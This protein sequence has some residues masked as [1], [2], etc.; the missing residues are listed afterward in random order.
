MT[1]EGERSSKSLDSEVR[2]M[3]AGVRSID[4]RKQLPLPIQ[5]D[6]KKEEWSAQIQKSANFLL[7]HLCQPTTDL[8][9]LPK[10]L[11]PRD[12][13]SIFFSVTAPEIPVALYFKRLQN[14]AKCSPSAFIV[15]MIYLKRMQEADGRLAITAYTIHRLLS[16]SILVAMKFLEEAWFP[17]EYY[18]RV[19]GMASVQEMNQLELGFLRL[20]KYR[21]Y[22]PQYE[23]VEMVEFGLKR[24]NVANSK[25]S[26]N[27]SRKNEDLLTTQEMDNV[28]FAKT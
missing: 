21:G 9:F 12:P 18:R 4:V 19:G 20:L 11:E 13:I 23:F 10:F 7:K 25:H 14:Y 22:V 6:D 5:V 1:I 2:F 28:T 3:E 24:A 8:A 15:A 27:G 16:A 26:H 17:N